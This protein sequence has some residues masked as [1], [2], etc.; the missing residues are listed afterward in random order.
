[1][2]ILSIR[3]APPGSGSTLARFDLE[4]T[5]DL[6]IFNLRLTARS[7]G[8]HSVFAPN[9]MGARVATFSNRLVDQIA[10][11]ALAALTE[12]SPNDSIKA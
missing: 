6:R 7:S 3:P 5:E 1:M 4:M 2:R 9:A 10:S 8:G 11:A 12:L